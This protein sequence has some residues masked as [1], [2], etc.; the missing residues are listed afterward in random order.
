MAQC[1]PD[2]LNDRAPGCEF[3]DAGW[4]LASSSDVDNFLAYAGTF[5]TTDDQAI[6]ALGLD[7]I[8]ALGPTIVVVDG[9]DPDFLVTEIWGI[10]SDVNEGQ[11]DT[12]YVSFFDSENPDKVDFLLAGGGPGTPIL[13]LAS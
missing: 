6:V 7:L 4:S 1:S 5:G 9:G 8:L 13:N 11:L 2:Q 10:T 3:F 12:R